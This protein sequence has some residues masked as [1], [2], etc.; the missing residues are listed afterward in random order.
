MAIQRV[1][2]I[3]FGVEDVESCVRFFEDFGL[4]VVDKGQSGADLRTL[5]NQVVQV[6]RSDDPGLL[7]PPETGSTLRLCTWGVDSAEGL[8]AV[9]AE[10]S[11]DRRVRQ[12]ADG[13]LYSV[14]E[15]GYHIAFSVSRPTP[16][17]V[18]PPRFNAGDHAARINSPF[19]V[20]V[21]EC[22]APLR[23]DHV[24]YRLRKGNWEAACA[25]YIDRL[26]FRLS[27]QSR[28]A[29][30]FMR[31]ETSMVH[32]NL[33]LMH[34]YDAVGIDHIAF[35]F[36]TF[37]DIMINGSNMV[38]RGWKPQRNPGRG[39]LGSNLHWFFNNPCGG[40][41][42]FSTDMNRYTED[43]VPRIFE[44]HPGHNIWTF[45]PAV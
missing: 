32:H 6:R 43:W 8:D 9:G 33:A 36:R 20:K 31:C 22:I 28:D 1:E 35:E 39:G 12:G 15:T 18:E 4:S 11:K 3:V 21:D 44:K 16:V 34:R 40:A 19:P 42:E 25:F 10:L 27:D 30:T 41:L 7:P 37:D 14:D 13:T 38:R 23:L 29:G 5:E 2:S 17:E 45:R 24:V 26:K